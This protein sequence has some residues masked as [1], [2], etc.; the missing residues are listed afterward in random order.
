MQSVPVIIRAR[1]L[2][3]FHV[4]VAG[5]PIG[6]FRTHKAALLLAYLLRYPQRHS[7]EHLIRLFWNGM[8]EDSARNNLR[9][10][11]ATLRPLLEPPGIPAGSVLQSGRH[12]VGLVPEVIETDVARFEEAL[13]QA[14]ITADSE[15]R[16]RLLEQA[17]ALYHGEFLAGYE[18]PW[19]Q[20]ERERL[21]QA[22]ETAWQQIQTPPKTPSEFRPRSYSVDAHAPIGD[23]LGIVLGLEWRDLS[24]TIPSATRSVLAVTQGVLIESTPTGLRACFRSVENLLKALDTLHRQFR[25]CRFAL[26]V[27]ELRYWMGRYSGVP[28]NT[29][30]A[31]LRVGWEG[32]ILCTER[33]VLLIPQT[34]ASRTLGLRPLGLYRLPDTGAAEQIYQLDFSG[35]EKEFAPLQAQ[36]PLRRWLVHV[37]T[38]FVG[39]EQEKAQLQALLESGQ[40]RLITLIGPPGVGKSRLAL[41]AAWQVLPRFGEACWWISLH[42][43]HE[44]ITEWLARQ[45]GWEWRG[46]ESFVESLK[47]VLEGHPA[48]LVLDLA[49]EISS[50]QKFELLVLRERL[51]NLCCLITAPKP[52]GLE[53]EQL[54]VLEPLPVPPS[55]VTE[56]TQMLR[57]ASVQLLVERARRAVPNFALTKRNAAAVGNLCRLLEG[58]PLAIEQASARIASG[59]LTELVEQIQH[60]LRWL[61]ER[62]TGMLNRSLYASLLTTYRLLPNP[63]Q[64]F[65]AR[66]SVFRGAFSFADAQALAPA[67][68]V[69]QWMQALLRFSLVQQEGAQY[70]LLMPVRLFAEEQLHA[71][72]LWEETKSAHAHYFT[73]MAIEWGGQ[74]ALWLSIERIRPNLE[75]ALEWCAA[76]LP[77]RVLECARAL[78][79]FWERRG[80]DRGIY[81]I[82]CKLPTLLN[83]PSQQMEAA[84]IAVRLATR[85]GS[86]EQAAQLLERW[87]PL[88]E[89]FPERLESARLWIAAGFYYWMQGD[90][91]QS[92]HYLD[93]ALQTLQNL[94]APLDM[95][96]A[97]NH[98]AVVLWMQGELDA[99][100]AMLEQAL[101]I[102]DAHSAPFHRMQVLSNLA[103]VRYQQGLW[104]AAEGCCMET[105]LLARRWE[106]R[107]TLATQLTNWGAW[108]KERGEY[109]RARELNMQAFSL[110][111]ELNESVGEAAVLGNLA[112]IAAAEGDYET[113]DHL[114]RRCL[115]RIMKA[116]IRWYLPQVLEK[117]AELAAQ[118]G[119]WRDAYERSC[120]CLFAIL[121]DTGTETKEA[122]ILRNLAHMARAQNN[123][124]AA[125]RWLARTECLTGEPCPASDWDALRN[126]LSESELEA[127]RREAHHTT[128]EQICEELRPIAEA[129]LHTGEVEP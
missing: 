95:V 106:D 23:G 72:N 53:D 92:Q 24:G 57:Y 80:S 71:F 1:L 40:E 127:I 67:A 5:Q 4:E 15:E 129:I 17:C 94:N 104:E 115:E 56:P 101:A 54:M 82:L 91:A 3:G 16:R 49:H 27:G 109:A 19:V 44:S 96:E 13:R 79:L 11:L 31:L 41:E 118:Q 103:N 76:V 46:S 116:R 98:L 117:W 69:E 45:Q 62:P 12:W 2:G 26:D 83:D 60:S 87:L 120:A 78:L 34:R 85:R 107:R 81:Q 18:E 75:A 8:P 63:V 86:I 30:N 99:S 70:R 123:P 74:P 100:A 20:T 7:R 90:C 55:S 113:A 124:M 128:R 68:P 93:R 58:L 112:E 36:T 111:L 66:L 65:F 59:S 47:R 73:T 97:Q 108:L 25:E 10:A 52:V 89:R 122:T 125:A 50:A 102:A 114:F 105:L 126:Y 88:T 43:P 42:E 48:L 119:N 39:R 84:R 29:V 61:K 35:R 38:S 33:V 21:Q 77:T 22:Y 14:A 6:R 51:P 110:W 37:P 121:T 64:Q 32:Q 9:V 28:I